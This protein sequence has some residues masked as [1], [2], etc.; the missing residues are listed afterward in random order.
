MQ[1]FFNVFFTGVN[2]TFF[3]MHLSGLQG[4]PRKYVQMLD[5]FCVYNAISTFGSTTSLF[6]LFVFLS[7]MMERIMSL[8]IVLVNSKVVSQPHEV[9]KIRHHNFGGGSYLFTEGSVQR[10]VRLRLDQ[11]PFTSFV[12]Q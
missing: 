5:R 8:R 1:A 6:G 2:T 9:V 12:L 10:E 3:P 7:L 11:G 4:A